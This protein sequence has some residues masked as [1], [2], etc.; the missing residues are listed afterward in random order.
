MELSPNTDVFMTAHGARLLWCSC[1]VATPNM[2]EAQVSRVRELLSPWY[3][4]QKHTIT[5]EDPQLKVLSLAAK[6]EERGGRTSRQAEPA[7]LSRF[8]TAQMLPR[9]LK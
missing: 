2:D 4:G 1:G 9:A 8:S 7:T 6:A 5:V 3:N